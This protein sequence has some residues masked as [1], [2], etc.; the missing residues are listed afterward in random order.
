MKGTKERGDIKIQEVWE[1]LKTPQEDV[2]AKNNCFTLIS[3]ITA[4]I[5]E[6]NYLTACRKPLPTIMCLLSSQVLGKLG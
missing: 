4:S 5:R 6:F 3:I 2:S 1:Y